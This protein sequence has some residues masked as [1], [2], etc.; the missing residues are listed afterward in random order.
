MLFLGVPLM[1]LGH[2]IAIAQKAVIAPTAIRTRADM[3]Q[4]IGQMAAD[5]A[6]LD[7]SHYAYQ[8]AA[9]KLSTLYATLSKQAE[10]VGK[11]AGQATGS[12]SGSSGTQNL[13]T[14]TQQMQET[15]MSF[16]LQYLQLQEQMQQENQNYTT[17]S[18]VMKTRNA[19]AKN[20]MANIK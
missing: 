15:Q 2:Q 20:A 3:A 16:N 1:V 4:A 8:A 10:A 11:A 9:Q 5:L 14:A 6:A 12:A 13:M 18:N 17:L 19:T 7:K